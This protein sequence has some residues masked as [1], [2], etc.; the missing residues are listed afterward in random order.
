M[1]MFPKLGARTIKV[2]G[3]NGKEYECDR[4]SGYEYDQ[5]QQITEDVK[6]KISD[7]HDGSDEEQAETMQIDIINDAKDETVNIIS[8]KLPEEIRGDLFRLSYVETIDFAMYLAFG[9][10]DEQ[11]EDDND[12]EP[13]SNKRS[14]SKKKR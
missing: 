9:S 1:R 14:R 4:L 8:E 2:I 6:N 3:A 7:I 13:V 11:E 12:S 10:E 5:I